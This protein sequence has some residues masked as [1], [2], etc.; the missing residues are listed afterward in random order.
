MECVNV[1]YSYS[2]KSNYGGYNNKYLMGLSIIA[3][4]HSF[5]SAMKH[6]NIKLNLLTDDEGKNFLVDVCGLWFDN[7]DLL[8]NSVTDHFAVTQLY[9]Y[10]QP[11]DEKIIHV[12]LDT[13]LFTTF[14]ISI[15]KS[16]IFCDYIVRNNAIDRVAFQYC[17]NHITY[18]DDIYM[19]IEESY[20]RN[21]TI[22]SMETG[23]FGGSYTR[24][25]NDY[26][27]NA[28]NF[29]QR[30]KFFQNTNMPI[31]MRLVENIYAYAFFK[32]HNIIVD[33]LIDRTKE[34][35]PDMFYHKLEQL[36]Y[37]RLYGQSKQ[38]TFLIDALEKLV[39][40]Y[41]PESYLK[42]KHLK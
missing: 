19:A 21:D 16:K 11:N 4:H 33:T 20:Y 9:A 5:I 32:H 25:I 14:P 40:N 41:Y 2:S 30:N 15:L 3:S 17:R 10:Q 1:I 38:N 39:K 35:E 24:L 6:L 23:V 26:S 29:F 13:F 34:T 8:F 28:L 36:N 7:V 42:I 12:N 37:I 31:I 18:K 27:L 22:W